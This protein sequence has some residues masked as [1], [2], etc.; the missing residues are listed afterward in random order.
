[1]HETL[2][3]AAARAML[4]AVAEHMIASTDTLTAADQAIGDGDH[5]IGM[6][7]GFSAVVEALDGAPAATQQALFKSIGMAIMAKTGGAAGAVFGTFFTAGS[8]AFADRDAI[9]GASFAE[10]LR[11]G[12]AG[13]EKRGG[14]KE[15]Q[16]T[17]IDA[18]A[19]AARAAAER[20]QCALPEVVSAAADAATAGV[21]ATR[22]MIAATG[23]ARTLGARSLGHP[24]PGAL[25]LSL[26]LAAMRDFIA[27]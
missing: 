17:M 27:T 9:D 10:F 12:L 20:R 1:M 25:S 16:K 8:A 24:D 26:M 21:A 4:A 6:R 11:L 5:G 7:R 3:L 14:A 13:V 23:K 2:S 19:P 15:G 22:D 18:L